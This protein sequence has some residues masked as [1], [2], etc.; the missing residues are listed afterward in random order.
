MGLSTCPLGGSKCHPGDGVEDPNKQTNV[1]D[2]SPAT[3]STSDKWSRAPKSIQDQ[4]TL[5]AAK[6]GYGEIIMEGLNDPRFKNFNK[7]ELKVKSKTGR[8]SVVHYVQDPNT[9]NITDFKFKKH[10]TEN[11]K[12]WGNDP[13]M[14]PGGDFK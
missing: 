6:E 13:S 5:E 10:S 4:M 12:P 11:M 7:V 14:P 9:G 1:D 8:D 3:P 2:G